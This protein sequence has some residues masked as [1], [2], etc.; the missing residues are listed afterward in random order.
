MPFL[1][2]LLPQLKGVNFWRVSAIS[3]GAGLIALICLVRIQDD[4]L[5][6]TKAVYEHPRVIR[7][8]Q[9]KTVQGPVRIV[10]RT[11]RTPGREEVTTEETRGPVVITAADNSTTGPV[12]AV[13]TDRW[14]AGFGPSWHYGETVDWSVMAG[15]SF[16]NRIDLLGGISKTGRIQGDLIFRF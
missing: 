7:L 3:V 6:Q 15:R 16:D 8:V 5:G 12:L 10:T 11:I 13:R 2:S 4:A 1:L 9:T 14:L